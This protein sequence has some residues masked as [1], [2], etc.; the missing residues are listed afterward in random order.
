MKKKK[1]S[2]RIMV[3]AGVMSVIA[4]IAI[5]LVEK[6][7]LTKY[8]KVTVVVAKTDISA[9][10][11]IT[12]KNIGEYFT[13][14]EIPKDAA[15][16]N[17]VTELSDVKE[18]VTSQD[19]QSKEQLTSNKMLNTTSDVLESFNEPVEVSLM[20]ENLSFAV[21][22]TLRK[23]DR[24]DIIAYADV[25][26]KKSELV[27]SD[28]YISGTYDATGAEV[29][30]DSNSELINSVVFN[31]IIEKEDYLTFID[32]ISLGGV[33]LIKVNNLDY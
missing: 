25:L 21:S 1:V 8:E 26:D 19:M 17:V 27:L 4:F 10:T 29:I 12:E 14:M 20:V 33:K 7:M 6:A 11:Y 18:Y 16:D 31:F 13:T 22:G 15:L 9:K 23:S 3:I 2:L 28:V 5:L 32:G 30:A 24:V